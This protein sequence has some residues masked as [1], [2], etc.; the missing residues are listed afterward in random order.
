M[1]KINEFSKRCEENEKN[2]FE[3]QSKIN[4]LLKENINLNSRIE[5]M[6][7]IDINKTQK[8]INDNLL[9]E[10]NLNKFKEENSKLKLSINKIKEEN[11]LKIKEN[12]LIIK[13]KKY[14][15]FLY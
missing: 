14:Q 11:F 2:I 3:Y 10:K 6:I 4:S 12:D 7:N 13:E 8:N 15:I 9:L 1:N 5:E